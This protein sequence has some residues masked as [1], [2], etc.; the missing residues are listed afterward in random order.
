MHSAQRF[1]A[2]HFRERAARGAH[3]RRQPD[4][5]KVDA[6][7]PIIGA[8]SNFPMALDE[9]DHRLF[10][11]CRRPAKVLIFD[12]S[13]GKAVGSVDAVGDSELRSGFRRK[14]SRRRRP[15]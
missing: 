2:V 11:A 6:I 12:T 8:Q 15:V 5:M 3:R 10:I 14:T 4:T 1:L 7:W 13:S 9:A